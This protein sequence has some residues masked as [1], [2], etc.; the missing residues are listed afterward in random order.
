MMPPRQSDLGERNLCAFE[1]IGPIEE[2]K[3]QR[4]I[5][6]R[7]HGRDQVKG[8]KHDAD[9]AASHLGKFVLAHSRKVP[10]RDDHLPRCCAFQ[11]RHHHQER[12]FAGAARP[13]QRNRL[14]FRRRKVYAA[15]DIDRP[16]SALESKRHAL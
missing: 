6:D 13:N 11:P 14:S 12:G 4:H 16:R 1:C 8:L 15:Q 3:R 9:G 10:A 5:L 2:L 7:G